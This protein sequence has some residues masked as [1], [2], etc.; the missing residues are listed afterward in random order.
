MTLCSSLLGSFSRFVDSC[1]AHMTNMVELPYQYFEDPHET[2]PI[3]SLL[4]SLLTKWLN[5]P[6]AIGRASGPGNNTTHLRAHMHS[7]ARSV[8]SGLFLR[9]SVLVLGRV[10]SGFLVVPEYEVYVYTSTGS[11]CQIYK[12]AQ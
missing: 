8:Y 1:V 2:F 10:R 3:M 11:C 4:A 9:V 6:Q 12:S 5:Y 7:P